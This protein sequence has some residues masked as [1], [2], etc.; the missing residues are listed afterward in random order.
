L[1]RVGQCL[2]QGIKS[3]LIRVLKRR[4]L[5]APTTPAIPGVFNDQVI[6]HTLIGSG[7]SVK[8]LNHV[9]NATIKTRVSEHTALF[10]AA[11]SVGFPPHMFHLAPLFPRQEDPGDVVKADEHLQDIPIGRAE[12]ATPATTSAV[13]TK[14]L[15]LRR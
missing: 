4:N 13:R 8:Y 15:R 5:E 12:F 7:S 10:L 1:F 14:L 6:L 2:L 9:V 3:C 11:P